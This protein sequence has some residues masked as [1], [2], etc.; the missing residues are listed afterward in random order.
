MLQLLRVIRRALLAYTLAATAFGQITTTGI[1]GIVRDP[2]GAVIPNANIKLRDLGTNIEQ[3]T[4]SS[5]EGN[6]AF[7]NLQAATYKLTASATGFQTAVYDSVTVDTGRITDIAVEMKVGAAT[8]T[9]EVSASAVQ[10]ETTSNEV[11]TTITTNLI[12]NLPY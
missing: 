11:G 1:H 4:V 5:A 6:F 10:L 8:E 2:S 12:Q 3:S 7:A 9:V